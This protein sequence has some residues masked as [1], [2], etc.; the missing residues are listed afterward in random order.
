[1]MYDLQ[2]VPKPQHKLKICQI[3]C[4]RVSSLTS[5]VN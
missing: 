4:T 3:M 5:I 1:M 2:Y